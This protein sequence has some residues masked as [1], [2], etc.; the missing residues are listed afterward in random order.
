MDY[1]IV[2]SDI[3][4]IASI[5][6]IINKA[7]FKYN[8]AYEIKT[9]TEY[10]QGLQEEIDDLSKI[11]IFILAIDLRTDIDGI[12]IAQQIRAKDLDNYII[13]VTNHVAMFETV[14]RSIH[15]I[16]DFIE[17]F[18][19]M[20]SRLTKDLQVLTKYNQ[21]NKLFKYKSR[22]TDIKILLK[23]IN[24]IYRDT[25]GRHVIIVTDKNNFVVPITLCAIKSKLDDRFIQVHRSCIVNRSN[26][27][28]IDWSKGYF[29]LNNG[30][31]LD[32]VSKKYRPNSS[33]VSN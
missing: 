10:C 23:S 32:R 7:I 22:N 13:F 29:T 14:H 16:Y 6:S 25:Y 20:S 9:F 8:F 1:I 12:Q 17:K 5:K 21:D 19:N 3:E 33:K 27:S 2:D 24:Y 18:N 15:N 11:K 4:A 31:T 28:V 26:I 30:Q